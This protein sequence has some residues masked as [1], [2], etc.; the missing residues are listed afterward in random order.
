MWQ[1]PATGPSG[2]HAAVRLPEPLAVL[3]LISP[4]PNLEESWRDYDGEWGWAVPS[5]A[6]IPDLQPAV[7]IV[8]RIHPAIGPPSPRPPARTASSRPPALARSRL[9]QHR[10]L[11]RLVRA[12]VPPCRRGPG[13]V[14]AGE[15]W[16]IGEDVLLAKLRLLGRAADLAL[17]DAIARWHDRRHEV[18]RKDSSELDCG[19]SALPRRSGEQAP[20][21]ELSYLSR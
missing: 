4:Y 3:S 9:G 11:L 13:Q 19:L 5:V 14:P 21:R 20:G 12:S 10:H 17:E 18:T 6:A 16:G 7:Q 2:R 15:W 1:R 8:A